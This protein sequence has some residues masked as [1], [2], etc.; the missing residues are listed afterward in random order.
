MNTH[1][2]DHNFDIFDGIV[3]SYPIYAMLALAVEAREVLKGCDRKAVQSLQYLIDDAVEK[4]R[5]FYVTSELDELAKDIRESR[6]AIEEHISEIRAEITTLIPDLKNAS[7]EEIRKILENLRENGSSSILPNEDD[8]DELDA[9]DWAISCGELDSDEPEKCVA[10]LALR[11][12]ASYCYCITSPDTDW[13]GTVLMPAQVARLIHA[14]N[15]AFAAVSAMRLIDRY[16]LELLDDLA[17]GFSEDRARHAAKQR[18]A[19]DPKQLV[20]KQV[21]EHWLLWKKTPGRYKNKSAFS[22][23]MLDKYELLQNQRVLERWCKAWETAL[24]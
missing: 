1:F 10:I 22:R 6:T 17:K 24:S 15:D 23:D 13:E 9:L 3:P 11:S 20:K 12:I 18:Y 2:E 7:V 19:H 5:E 14:S 4:I 21:H 8:L 16:R